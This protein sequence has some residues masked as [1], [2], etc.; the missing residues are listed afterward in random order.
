MEGSRNLP[1]TVL[2]CILIAVVKAIAISI[3]CIHI[4]VSRFI[5]IQSRS[6][7][8]SRSLM[9]SGMSQILNKRI[10]GSYTEFNTIRNTVAINISA[11]SFIG[12]LTITC[13]I[14]IVFGPIND[15]IGICI[16]IVNRKTVGILKA[17]AQ[18]IVI[19]IVIKRITIG[20][21][22]CIIVQAISICIALARIGC[23]V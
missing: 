18:A 13:D 23:V 22:V 1:F 9:L 21:K 8:T 10:V 15:A 7:S 14:R 17:I 2:I 12:I 11:C 3:L 20:R 5:L 19:C 4:R 16:N 6:S